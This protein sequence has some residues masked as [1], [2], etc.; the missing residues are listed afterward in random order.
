[1]MLLAQ[2]PVKLVHSVSESVV[3]F[4]SSLETLDAYNCLGEIEIWTDLMHWPLNSFPCLSFRDGTNPP[5]ILSKAFFSRF[6]FVQIVYSLEYMC[7]KY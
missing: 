4:L 6:T 3:K 7:V 2:S 5:H 1:M